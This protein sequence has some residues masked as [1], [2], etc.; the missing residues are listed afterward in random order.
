MGRRW[1]TRPGHVPAM[2]AIVAL[3]VCACGGGNEQDGQSATPTLMGGSMQ[4]VPLSLMGTTS[5]FAGVS[6]V[7]SQ[8]GAGPDARFFRPGGIATDGTNLYVSDTENHAIRKVVIATGAVTTLAGLPELSGTA[9][10]TASAARFN[11]PEGIATDGTSLYVADSLNSTIRKVVIATGEVTTLAGTAGANGYA[12]GAGAAARFFR[13]HGITTDGTNLYVADLGSH[14]IRKVVIATTEVTTLA[15]SW[16]GAGYADGTGA[17]AEFLGPEG[18]ATDGTNLYVAE[19]MNDTIRKIVIATAEVT[20]LAGAERQFGYADGTGAAAR[21]SSPCGISTDNTNLYVAD[22]RNHTIRKVVIATTEVTTLAG[23]APWYGRADGTGAAARFDHPF[24]VTT[25]GTNVYVADGYNNAV[26]TVAIATAQVSTLAGTPATGA[27][28]GIG[29]A[30]RFRNPVGVTTDGENLYVADAGNSTIRKVV[31]ATGQATTLA[32]TAG[33]WGYA[34]GTEAS[35]RF[36]DVL[37]ITTDGTNIYVTDQHTS[38]VR[39][40]I[41]ATGAVTTLA[42]TPGRAGHADGTGAAALF[43]SPWGIT[44]DGTNLYVADA[45]NRTIRKVVI[46]TGEVTTL[47]GTPLATGSEDG[48]GAAARFGLPTGI[49][50]DGVN[51][52][53]TDTG[54]DAVRKVVIATGEVTTVA[55]TTGAWPTRDST[56]WSTEW[57]YHLSGIATDGTSLYV[58]GTGNN[59]IRKIAIA[60]GEVTTLAGTAWPIGST[61]GTGSAARFYDPAGITTDGKR[62]FAAD[63]GNNTIRAIE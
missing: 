29:A 39:K 62:L 40:I 47:A 18:I 35:A 60:T 19:S 16:G 43:S 23:T 5:T 58:T 27:T 52:Y 22:S 57:T 13:P 44:T 41:I 11:R 32:G 51:L 54:N 1:T 12:D 33:S 21:F 9:D 26:R 7:G 46:A 30:A 38:T 17:A 49:T 59:T 6:V 53:V 2:L 8:D 50:T 48:T 10:G 55:A 61:D 37:G 4:G 14:T 3:L 28:D 42:G 15:G 25:D 45:H 63:C 36:T 20:T 56:A 34:D 24:D 31:I